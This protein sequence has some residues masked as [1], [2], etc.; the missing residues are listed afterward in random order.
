MATSST[1]IW[2]NFFPSKADGEKGETYD[3]IM[4]PFDGFDKR[5]KGYL[6]SMPTLAEEVSSSRGPVLVRWL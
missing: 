1:D 3:L 6:G 2:T 5:T 4:E